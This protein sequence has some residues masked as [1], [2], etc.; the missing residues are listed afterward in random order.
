MIRH[1]NVLYV[2]CVRVSIKILL[3]IFRVAAKRNVGEM[4]RVLMML[5]GS[6]ALFIFYFFLC[7]DDWLARKRTHETR[8][9]P[10]GGQSGVVPTV[11]FFF[12]VLCG[13]PTLTAAATQT[14]ESPS[15]AGKSLCALFACQ[16]DYPEMNQGMWGV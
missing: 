2:L 16:G 12:F 11:F 5:R 9:E 3:P 14:T 13:V 4:V 6:L 1:D 10:W 8:S 15:D 7:H